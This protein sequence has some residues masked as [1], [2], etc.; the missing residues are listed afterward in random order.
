VPVD[1][2]RRRRCRDSTPVTLQATRACVT[3]RSAEVEEIIAV[4]RASGD[5]AHGRRLRGLIVIMW[6]AGLRIQ[7]AL[8]LTAGDLDPGRG[9]AL[10]RRGKGG[11]RRE[12]GMGAW[13]WE[14]LEPW[15]DVRRTSRSVRCYA[16]STA[17]RADGSGRQ[18][19]HV[20]SCGAPP[21]RQ[22]CGV[23]SRHISSVTPTPSRWPARASR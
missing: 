19:R 11:R 14:Q 22:E 4:L 10:V 18:L 15:L 2:D 6:R 9:A 5:A 1:V 7:E 20:P 3:G 16:S 21:A 12:V 17:R 13:G 8:A 23:A